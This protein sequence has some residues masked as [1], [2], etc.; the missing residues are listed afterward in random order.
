V[1]DKK[2]DV[3]GPQIDGAAAADDSIQIGI[4][5]SLYI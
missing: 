3:Y 1:D 2:N 5:L 4:F